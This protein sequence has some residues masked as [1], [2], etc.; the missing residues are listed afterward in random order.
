[1]KR[2]LFLLLLFAGLG[3]ASYFLLFA[4]P[5]NTTIARGDREFAVKDVDQIEK[6]F[7]ADRDGNQTTLV[8]KS[9]YWEY[10]GKHKAR[11]SVMR[12]LLDVIN[13]V[14]VNYVVARAAMKNIVNDMASYGIKVEIYGKENKL[15]KAYYVG[16]MT[17]DETGTYMIMDGSNEP[18]VTHIP[19]W[20]GG[21]RARY[22]LSGDEWRDRTVFSQQPDNIKAISIEYPKQQVHS[23]RLERKGG[24]FDVKPFSDD[25][26]SVNKKV[27]QGKVE[28]FLY[29]FE[30]LAGEAFRNEMDSRDSIVNSVPFCKVTMETEDGELKKADFYPMA[31]YRA[32]GSFV[33][34]QD[35]DSEE[36]AIERYFADM[37]TGDFIMVQHRVFR[38]IF[39]PYNSFFE[40]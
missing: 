27:H 15:L 35:I 2:T 17:N 40:D 25:S 37:S 39:R 33:T 21:L 13:R 6:I 11:P 32:D 9:D 19:S 1:M 23:F 14:D 7:I 31:T 3:G 18:Y 24:K 38:P 29:S 4:K 34:D 20:Q 30:S 26:P 36:T 12:T 5:S 8:R 10:N 22:D 28:A 16:G